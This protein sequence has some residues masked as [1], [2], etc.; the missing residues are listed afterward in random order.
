[1][2]TPAKINLRKLPFTIPAKDDPDFAALPGH[3]RRHVMLWLNR[4]ARIWHARPITGALMRLSRQHHI[5]YTTLLRYYY[6]LLGSRDWRHLID[7]R[8]LPTM[9]ITGRVYVPPSGLR[10]RVIQRSNCEAIIQ[11]ERAPTTEGSAER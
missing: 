8:F 1:M 10:M 4:L 11:I 5:G 7:H 2:S 9:P 6:D 3:Q